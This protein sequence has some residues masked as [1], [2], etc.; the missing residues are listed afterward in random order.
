MYVSNR[1]NATVDFNGKRVFRGGE[2]SIAVF[3]ITS[4]TGEPTLVQNADPLSFH[5]RT[6]SIDPGGRM[7]VAASIVDLVTVRHFNLYA[8]LLAFIGHNDPTLGATPP[9]LYAASCRWTRKGKQTL[10]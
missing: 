5:I 10:L 2:N 9:P 7:L 3:S 8:E 1:A 6:F 4:S